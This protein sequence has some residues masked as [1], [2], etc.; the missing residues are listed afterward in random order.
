VSSRNTVHLQPG[1]QIGDYVVDAL[2]GEGATGGVYRA[3][4]GRDGLVVALKVLKR[5]LSRDAAFVGRF[6]REAR[7][8][9]SVKHP[10]LVPVV[11]S[12]EHAGR[13][14]LVSRFYD[15]GSLA[16]LI[17]RDGRLAVDESI[18]LAAEVAS[19]LGALHAHGIVHRDVKPSN[20]MLDRMGAA[21]LTDF[22][23]ARSDAYTVLTIP[24]QVLGTL[25]YIA[26]ELIQ[27]QPAT[28]ESDVYSLGCLVYECVTGSPPFADRGVFEV[29]VAH[30][31]DA[32]PDPRE[33]RD[34]VGAELAWALVRALEKDPSLRPPT[35]TA[36][37]HM[38]RATLPTLR[39][40]G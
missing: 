35:A 36:Y 13:L 15:T 29:A 27:G 10:H 34:T 26:P 33:R 14:Y 11:E 25:D 18:R 16:D 5:G 17:D 31:E 19:G 9:A 3:T 1:E 30:L 28:S 22:G 40:P 24:G 38:L 23:L 37:A 4:R 6:V 39:S 2:L 7:I 32:P 8:A 20:V 21:A 12:G